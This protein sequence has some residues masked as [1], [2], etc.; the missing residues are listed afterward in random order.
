[1]VEVG[2][3]V[4][5]AD[6]AFP[7]ELEATVAP[8]EML[9]AGVTLTVALAG[10]VELEEFVMT[11]EAKRRCPVVE[12]VLLVLLETVTFG[13]VPLV[14]VALVPL[15]L[16]VELGREAFEVLLETDELAEVALVWPVRLLW[17][18]FVYE[19]ELVVPLTFE[20]ELVLF[21]ELAVALFKG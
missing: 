10:T 3:D 13:L 18:T 5:E 4:L 14:R 6:D 15:V 16:L 9:D 1:M 11:L 19:E 7:V 20:D 17:V 21:V 8:T 2:V 12:L